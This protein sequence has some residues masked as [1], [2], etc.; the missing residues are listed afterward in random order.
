MGDERARQTS[1][2]LRCQAAA[3]LRWFQAV[4]SL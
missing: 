1:Q 4:V 2:V 3:V